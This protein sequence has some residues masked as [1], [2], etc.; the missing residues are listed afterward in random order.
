MLLNR[1]NENLIVEETAWSCFDYDYEAF[2]NWLFIVNE[3]NNKGMK[4]IK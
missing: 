2:G 3:L 4:I 1:R